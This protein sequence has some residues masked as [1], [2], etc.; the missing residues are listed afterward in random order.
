MVMV[1]Q[2]VSFGFGALVGAL[3][4]VG[5]ALLTA[6]PAQAQVIDD[7]DFDNLGCGIFEAYVVGNAEFC[8]IVS[9][10]PSA[11]DCAKVCKRSSKA[12]VKTAKSTA[13][14]FKTI[15]KAELKV[16]KLLCRTTPDPRACKQGF[17]PAKKELNSLIKMLSEQTKSEC[18]SSSLVEGCEAVCNSNPINVNLFP[19]CG[20]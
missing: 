11:D 17:R 12:C 20:L 10:D 14:L 19:S 2:R 18:V 13:R 3:L 6:S 16:A 4:L 5:I 15:V 9:C 8:G 7:E 1:K